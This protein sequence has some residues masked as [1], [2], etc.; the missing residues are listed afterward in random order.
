MEVL[1]EQPVKELPLVME[2]PMVVALMGFL[3]KQPEEELPL[4]A[5]QPMVPQ[6]EVPMEF[7]VELPKKVATQTCDFTVFLIS[8]CSSS[9][10]FIIP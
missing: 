4:P 6:K 9:P 5:Q 3:V 2:L 7:V 8:S 10:F 1:V